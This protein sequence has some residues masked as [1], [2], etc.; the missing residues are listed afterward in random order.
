[1][2][3]YD[4]PINLHEYDILILDLTNEQKKEYKKEEHISTDTKQKN[5]VKLTCSYPTTVF[6]PRPLTSSFLASSVSSIHGRKCLQIV[7][8]CKSYDIEYKIV[9]IT[10]GNTQ[11][12]PDEKYN[13]YSFNNSISLSK[14]RTG[15][16]VNVCS[17]RDEISFLLNK[18]SR[19]LTYYQTF[20][21]PMRRDSGNKQIPDP[22]ITPLLKNINDEIVSFARLDEHLATFV[23]PDIKDKAN[24]L[25]EFLKNFCPSIV[26]ELFPYS[27]QFKW[28]ESRDYFL[29]NHSTLLIDLL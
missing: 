18:H 13:I 20:N 10:N 12:F 2:H 22:T 7:F 16:E 8:A 28:K 23:F 9:N 19:D 24:F 1:M 11:R 29:P 6:D 26:P 15:K 27:T 4:L 5:V 25:R 14:S 21:H 3:D 17:V